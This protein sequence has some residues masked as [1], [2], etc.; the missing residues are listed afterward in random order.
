[1]DSRRQDFYAMQERRMVVSEAKYGSVDLKYP[2]EADALGNLRERLRRYESD[3]N[4]DWLVD[5]ANF[6]MIEFMCPSHRDAHL[7]VNTE[8][9]G[10]KMHDGGRWH[11][12][13]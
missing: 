5:V 7:E 1:V 10:L 3:G 13:R 12:R 9:P 8:S 2:H 11:E 4:L 6:A